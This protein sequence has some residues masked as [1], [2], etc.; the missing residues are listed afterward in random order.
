LLDLNHKPTVLIIDEEIVN[1]QIL[2]DILQEDYHIKIAKSG[3]KALEVLNS[4][5]NIDLVLLDIQMPDISGYD[6]CKYIKNSDKLRHIPIIFVTSKDSKEDEEYG[7]RLGAIDY[8]TKPFYQAIV[9]IRVKNQIEL[10]LKTDLLEKLSMYDGLTNIK[11]RRY[12]DESF[13][14][15]C[16]EARREKLNIALIMMDIDLFKPYNDNYG[17]GQGDVALKKVAQ[18]LQNSI[19]RPTDILARYGGEEF[20]IALKDIDKQGLEKILHR[21]QE[22]IK[23]LA[24]IH[25]YSNVSNLLTL[26]MGA[27]ISNCQNIN[28]EELLKISDEALY[29]VKNSGRNNYNIVVL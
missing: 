21:I 26:S 9:K 5:S 19:K 27:V 1:L 17:H 14:R 24:I 8:I 12:F 23:D 29:K 3:T 18:G 25:E 13:E 28:K 6:V 4:S 2:A 16:L 7:L 15:L 20:I 22:N 10:K 11:N